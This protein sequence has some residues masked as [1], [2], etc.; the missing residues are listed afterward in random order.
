VKSRSLV[1]LTSAILSGLASTIMNPPTLAQKA[2][3]TVAPTVTQKTSF[4][5]NIDGLRSKKGNVMVCLWKKEDKDFPICSESLTNLKVPA[6]TASVM[7]TFANLPAGEYAISAFHDENSNNKIDRG[8]MGIPSEGMA[9]SGIDMSQGRRERPS[10]DRAK[11][12]LNGSKTMNLT[13]R[14]MR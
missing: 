13:V 8:F 14:Y 9:M 2:S 6:T 11:F 5:I 12:T 10:F 3:P 4:T 1:L 7:V